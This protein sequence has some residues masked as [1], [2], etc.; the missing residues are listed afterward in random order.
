MLTVGTAW[1]AVEDPDTP[2]VKLKLDFHQPITGSTGIVL[3]AQNYASAWQFIAGG[4][5][6]GITTFDRISRGTGGHIGG[7][8]P[9]DSAPV[10]TGGTYGAALDSCI[11]L[12]IGSSPVIKYLVDAHGW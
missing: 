8:L 4:G 12:G 6:V 11:L 1:A 9:I 3:I 10:V 2:L 7:P 5:I